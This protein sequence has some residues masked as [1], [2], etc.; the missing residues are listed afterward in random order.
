VSV[1]PTNDCL[2]GRQMETEDARRARELVQQLAAIAGEFSISP[3]ALNDALFREKNEWAFLIKAH[4]LV[5]TAVSHLIAQASPDPRLAPVFE[6]L[7]KA[8]L[9]RKLSWAAK[10]HLLDDNHL[11]A[12]RLLSRIRNMVVHDIRQVD[13]TFDTFLSA[14][15]LRGEFL[16]AFT[17]WYSD[18]TTMRTSSPTTLVGMAVTLLLF[19]AYHS[20]L[21]TKKPSLKNLG[22]GLLD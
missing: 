13:F 16:D 7:S 19:N 15:S 12:A 22:L 5:E 8:S 20:H 14:H 6:E 9:D 11:P 1:L 3:D 21:E 4:A 18:S 17:K 10:M 2:R